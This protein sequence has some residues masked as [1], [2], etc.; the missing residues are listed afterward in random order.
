MDTQT[1]TVIVTQED[2]DAGERA[3]CEACP[4]ALALRRNTPQ[5]AFV[6][7]SRVWIGDDIETEREGWLPKDAVMFVHNFDS[8]HRDDCAPFS[9]ELELRPCAE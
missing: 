9:F 8:G 3:Q 2:I 4:V 1:I 6:G 5:R 7:A